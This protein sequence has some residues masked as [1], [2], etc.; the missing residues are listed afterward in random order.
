MLLYGGRGPEHEVSGRD[1]RRAVVYSVAG[2]CP[3][4]PCRA[5]AAMP[6]LTWQETAER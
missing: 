4:A 3:P 5:F 6:P 1:G 2:N